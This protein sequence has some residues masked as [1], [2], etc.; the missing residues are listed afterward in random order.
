M[1]DTKAIGT[2]KGPK[3][4]GEQHSNFMSA[5]SYRGSMNIG[6]NKTATEVGNQPKSSSTKDV[7]LRTDALK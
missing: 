5:A 4:G 7:G 3:Q 2:Q 6:I 1:S